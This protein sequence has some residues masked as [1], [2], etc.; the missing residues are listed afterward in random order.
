MEEAPPQVPLKEQQGKMSESIHSF[1]FSKVFLF[2]I[3][4]FKF[5]K[6]FLY[7]FLSKKK[8]AHSEIRS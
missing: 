8:V 5:S 6:E 3:E 7:N 1:I 4:G 2:F